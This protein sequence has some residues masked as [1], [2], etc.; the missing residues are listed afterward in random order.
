MF[1]LYVYVNNDSSEMIML[2]IR[3]KEYHNNIEKKIKRESDL[4]DNNNTVLEKN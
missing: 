2:F 4:L 1:L 3:E